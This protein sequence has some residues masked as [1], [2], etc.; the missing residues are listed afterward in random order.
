M[1]QVMKNGLIDQ[2]YLLLLEYIKVPP[3]RNSLHKDS[4]IGVLCQDILLHTG[5]VYHG[6]RNIFIL[7]TA[8]EIVKKTF[9]KYALLCEDPMV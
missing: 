7:Q 2:S 1:P 9:L 5:C 4:L 6:I 8:V 3:L